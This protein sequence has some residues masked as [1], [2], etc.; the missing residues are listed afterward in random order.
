MIRVKINKKSFSDR[1]WLRYVT[2]SGGSKQVSL[3]SCANSFRLATENRYDTGD[4]LQCV[5]W[6]YEKDGDLC[7]ELFCVG[8]VQLYMSLQPSLKDVLLYLLKGKK[9]NEAHQ[10]KLEAFE[11]AL[12]ER[13]WKTVE[14]PAEV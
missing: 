8:H 9:I 12:N 14:K 10:R 6:R 2:E 5:G 1:Y 3:P 11:L 4:G 13:G 7:Y